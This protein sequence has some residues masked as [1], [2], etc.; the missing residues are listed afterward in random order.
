MVK[1]WPHGLHGHSLEKQIVVAKAENN[2]LIS[3][4]IVITSDK[5]NYKNKT[6]DSRKSKLRRNTSRTKNRCK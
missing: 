1:T 5:L 2:I 3:Y 4:S 6:Y